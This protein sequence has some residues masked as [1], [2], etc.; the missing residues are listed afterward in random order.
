MEYNL[1]QANLIRDCNFD[2]NDRRF[3][4]MCCNFLYIRIIRSSLGGFHTVAGSTSDCSHGSCIEEWE[5]R[6]TKSVSVVHTFFP[7]RS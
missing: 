3:E 2:E 6:R 7:E 1:E 5:K 4:I